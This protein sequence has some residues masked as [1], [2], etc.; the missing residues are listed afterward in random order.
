MS[1][2]SVVQNPV[3]GRIYEEKMKALGYKFPSENERLF[4]GSTD[5]GDVSRVVPA[6]HPCFSIPCNNAS[7]HSPPFA[8]AAKS[9]ESFVCAMDSAEGLAKTAL[10]VLQ[11]KK[12]FEEMKKSFAET[13]D[14]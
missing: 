5:M 12:L 8:E 7:A 4:Q 2:D 9:D 11:N 1:Y 14:S 3:L 13:W 6:I 10:E